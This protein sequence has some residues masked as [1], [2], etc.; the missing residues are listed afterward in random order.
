MVASLGWVRGWDGLTEALAIALCNADDSMSHMEQTDDH[1]CSECRVR[2]ERSAPA[3]RAHY[4]AALEGLAAEWDLTEFPDETTAA[5]MRL[6]L[7]ALA[8]RLGVHGPTDVTDK[9]SSD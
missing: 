4:A 6:D 8:A 5:M 3:V 2:A 1:P 9:S 7:L